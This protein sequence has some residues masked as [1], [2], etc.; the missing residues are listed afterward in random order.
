ML[1]NL[2]RDYLPYL[3]G[4]LVASPYSLSLTTQAGYAGVP[5]KGREPFQSMVAEGLFNATLLLLDK[6][7]D[8][9]LDYC[10]PPTPSGKGC[11]PRV[12]ISVIGEDG[13]W[14]LPGVAVT[15]REIVQKDD[16]GEKEKTVAYAQAASSSLRPSPSHLPP[17]PTH[18]RIVIT[19]LGVFVLA[20]VLMVLVMGYKLLR[21]EP[22]QRFLEWPVLRVLAPPVT[23]ASASR[24]HT[25]CL[26]LCFVILALI[27][28]WIAAVVVPFVRTASDTASIPAALTSAA[29]LLACGLVLVALVLL[30]LMARRAEGLPPNWPQAA[31]TK[32]SWLL[33]PALPLLLLTIGSFGVYLV[34]LVKQ[35]P[36]DLDLA[37]ARLVGG[38]IVSPAPATL[39]LFAGLY[40][41]LFAA[42]RRLS[43]VGA[44]YT[45][46]EQESSAFAL[47][48]GDSGAD[49]RTTDAHSGR[50]RLGDVL[51]MPGQNL[52]LPYVITILLG[53]LIAGYS[54]WD[55]STIDGPAFGWFLR[56]AS[57]MVLMFGLLNVAQGLLIWTT[58]S[59][60]LKRLALTP[61]EGAFK[62]IAH[63]VP[64]DLSWR[65][66]D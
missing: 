26:V 13:F 61:I 64:W 34:E 1:C 8:K 44:G 43:L 3:R 15:Q 32:S 65:R 5:E 9:L 40:A 19:M 16:K 47:L 58:A 62:S 56:A 38:G 37:L 36:S 17:L 55:M 54:L 45:K 50:T 23:Y 6:D 14:P 57:A 24:L 10:D 60:H 30:I 2:H 27:S 29:T 39:F 53:I 12:T 35:G 28:A 41:G 49:A 52:S 63:L 33:M 11:M 25:F 59:A 51:D 48:N 31:R 46:L 4:T 18:A 66:R 20:H 21:G 22:A 7:S 42:A